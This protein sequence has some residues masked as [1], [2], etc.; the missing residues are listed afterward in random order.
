MAKGKSKRSRAPKKAGVYC[1]GV[2]PRASSR[3]VEV[4]ANGKIR[5]AKSAKCERKYKKPCKRAADATHAMR[6]T[7]RPRRKRG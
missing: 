6:F 7:K 2:K 1:V 3:C 4:S 5:F